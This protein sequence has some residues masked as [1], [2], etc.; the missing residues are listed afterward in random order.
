MSH[1]TIRSLTLWTP[2]D[3]LRILIP[4]TFISKL[5]YSFFRVN[6]QAPLSRTTHLHRSR[7]MFIPKHTRHQVLVR[8]RLLSGVPQPQLD[9]HLRRPRLLGRLQ[10]GIGASMTSSRNPQPH[11]RMALKRAMQPALLVLSRKLAPDRSLV[12]LSPILAVVRLAR[13]RWVVLVLTLHLTLCLS[14]ETPQPQAM[15]V[16]PAAVMASILL[17]V[18]LCLP[19]LVEL[20]HH[21]VPMVGLLAAALRLLITAL[22]L[23]RLRS[24]LSAMSGPLPPDQHILTNSST[25][26]PAAPLLRVVAPLASRPVPLRLHRRLQLLKPLLVNVARTVPP[27]R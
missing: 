10:I 1:A 7:R 23:R 5:V 8:P 26:V 11:P 22:S 12:V 18:D 17:Y 9:R 21:L 19:H 25:M 3:A 4:A 16:L 13:R 14:W 24:V 20:L 6:C 27:L 2:T 15:S